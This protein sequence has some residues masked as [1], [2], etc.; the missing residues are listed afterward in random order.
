MVVDA[1][2]N[3]IVYGVSYS[4]DFPVTTGAYSTTNSGNGDIIVSK[5]NAT[6]TAL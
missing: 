4:S 2:N 6:G 1:N 3:L 5:F